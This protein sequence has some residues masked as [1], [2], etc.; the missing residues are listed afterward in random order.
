MK[1]GVF[2][3]DVYF[4]CYQM[5]FGGDI[6][7]VYGISWQ[8]FG[9]FEYQR[10]E[11]MC[12]DLVG[13]VVDL[14]GEVVVIVGYFKWDGEYI[15]IVDEVMQ[16][17]FFR[18]KVFCCGDNGGYFGVVYDQGVKFGF[19]VEGVEGGYSFEGFGFVFCVKVDVGVV[20]GQL[21]DGIVVIE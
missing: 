1:G 18:E 6:Y 17:C 15:G 21:C 8:F 5:V 13:E 2:E 20:F 3:I 14:L 12:K 19:G 7:N 11:L 10:Q 9:S 4:G 16:Q